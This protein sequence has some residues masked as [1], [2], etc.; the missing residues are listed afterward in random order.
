V[1]PR[2]RRALATALADALRDRTATDRLG[3]AGRQLVLDNHSA[4]AVAHA[5][6]GWAAGD[7]IV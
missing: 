3:R 6:T 5:I 4:P 1:P 7:E 2:N